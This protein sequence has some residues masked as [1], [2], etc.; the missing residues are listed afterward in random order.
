MHAPKTCPEG[1]EEVRELNRLF[2]AFLH[3]NPASTAGKLGLPRQAVEALTAASSETREA[4]AA[5][6]YALFR[7]DLALLPTPAARDPSTPDLE[8][9]QQALQLTMLVTAWNLA[10]QSRYAARF[11][12]GLSDLDLEI[13]R[14]VPLSD[15]PR[16][17]LHRPLLRCA[18]KEAAWLW[19]ELLTAKRDESRHQL[20][21]L[22]LQPRRAPTHA[23]A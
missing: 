20:L 19:S 6:P 10:R 2:L 12:F 21:L 16:A 9:A 18:F 17:A 22:G 8:P 7:L 1:L 11:F 23:A 13:L 5:L 3:S 15:L 4:V 14:A